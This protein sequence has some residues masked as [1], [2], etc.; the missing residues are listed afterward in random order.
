MTVKGSARMGN[1]SATRAIVIEHAM[2]LATP[3]D[4]AVQDGTALTAHASARVELTTCVLD[5][6]RVIGAPM[7]M[8][9]VHVTLGTQESIVRYH[10]LAES[11]RPALDTEHATLK[12]PH[13]FAVSSFQE[14]TV[15][16]RARAIR[17]L[18]V[19]DTDSVNGVRSRTERVSVVSA[20]LHTTAAR[21]VLVGQKHRAMGTV[22]ATW[23][24]LA[25]AT[26]VC[27][28]ASGARKHAPRARLTGRAFYA[29]Y[30]VP[31]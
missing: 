6:E 12:P 21:A 9:L 1:A 16:L 17:R 11:P 10:A 14:V 29:M 3:V 2:F 13:A 8:A 24:K 31:K 7:V 18:C 22:C 20:T 27:R 19:R 23:T 5:T 26:E 4:S 28:R 30:R 15:R 25:H